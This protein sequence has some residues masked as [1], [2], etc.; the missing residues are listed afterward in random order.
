MLFVDASRNTVAPYTVTEV[1]ASRD[2]SF[3]SHAMSPQAVLQVW[4]QIDGE[5]TE[6]PPCRLL[7]IRG[8]QFEL[9]AAMSAAADA[10]LAAALEWAQ[11]WLAR[12]MP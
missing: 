6:P 11:G 10:N 2:A 1:V 8:E 5:G 7:A 4:H 12:G 3:T 9:G